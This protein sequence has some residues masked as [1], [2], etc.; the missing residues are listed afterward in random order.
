[1]IHTARSISTEAFLCNAKPRCADIVHVAERAFKLVLY[2]N[3]S[4][5]LWP[6]TGVKASKFKNAD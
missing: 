2:K 6:C 3:S 4:C 1:M 5:A